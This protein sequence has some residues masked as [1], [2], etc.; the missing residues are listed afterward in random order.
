MIAPLN[1]RQRDWQG[2]T[3]WLVGASSGIGLATATALHQA[4]ATV[5]VSARSQGALDEFA[6]QHTGSIAVAVD[7]AD[8]AAVMAAAQRVMAQGRLDTVLYCAGYYKEQ[9]ATEFDL[10]DML[11][12][13]QVNYVGALHVLAA[14]LPQLLRQGTGHVGLISSVAGYRGLPKSLAYGPTKAALINLAE[15]LY[16]DLHDR[17]IGISLICPGFVETPL[18]AQNGFAMP[19]LITPEAA[20]R[21]IL[22]G[23]ARGAFE[24]HFPR[25]FTLAM[26]LL[27]LLPF[28][29]YRTLVRR[30]TGL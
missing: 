9:R 12:H 13:Q 30:F 16:L 26:K 15:T 2:R 23:W 11:R 4:G 17:G 20:A 28:R 29:L 1:P 21:A 8:R 25:R 14:V 18:T 27:A 5:I 7:V 24:I 3:V 22:K 6:Q 10:D 19:A